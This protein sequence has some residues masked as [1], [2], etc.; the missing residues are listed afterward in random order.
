LGASM[1]FVQVYGDFSGYSDIAIG[2]A[3][4]FGFELSLNFSTPFFSR[5]FSEFWRRWHITL[6]TWFRDYV[7]FP[8]GGS[9]RGNTRHLINISI[10]FVVCGFWHGAAWTFIFWGALN[11]LYFVFEQKTKLASKDQGSL[12][13]IAFPGLVDLF[14]M[15]IVFLAV[16]FSLVFFRSPDIASAFDYYVQMVDFSGEH[17]FELGRKFE[18]GFLYFELPAY[19]LIMLGFEWLNRD[20]PHGLYKTSKFKLLRLLIYFGLTLLTL[21]YFYGDKAFVYFQF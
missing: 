6:N 2:T 16:A 21:Q 19:L 17:R 13:D 4:L 15:S 10:V 14:K 1:F 18:A 8:L 3:R 5:S 11:A 7:Y 12:R 9:R 20:L